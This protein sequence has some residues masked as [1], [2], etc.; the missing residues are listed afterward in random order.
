MKFRVHLYVQVRVE[1]EL[2]ADT[3]ED[4]A[5]QAYEADLDLYR[6]FAGPDQEYAEKIDE[7]C[8]VDPLT[9]ETDHEGRLLP[10]EEWSQ[11][12][13]VTEECQ[14][15]GTWDKVV[16]PALDASVFVAQ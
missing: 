5:R 8:L 2:E 9:E 12:L 1:Q 16:T 4:A 11:Y 15:D 6:R 10:D 14:P 3:A 13:R 7:V